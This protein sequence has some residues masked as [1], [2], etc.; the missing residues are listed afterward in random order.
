MASPV[1]SDSAR[2]YGLDW[3][4]VFAFL[5][6]IFYHSGM[7]FVT[8]PWHVKNPE[9]STALEYAMLFF[10]H[11]RLGLLFFI[12]GAGVWFSL[13]RRGWLE[14][15]GERL[16]RLA[17]PVLFGI[18]VIVPPQIYFERLQQGRQFE[19]YAAFYATVFAF[20][21]YPE[22][23]TSWHHLWFVVY[24][25]VYS[26]AAIPFFL[27]WRRSAGTA[28]RQL[29][30]FLLRRQPV[31]YLA[32]LP[33][34][35]IALTLGP[36]W[37]VTHNLVSD[38]ANL[39]GSFVTFLWG[40]AIC[41]RPALLDAITARRREFLAGGLLV[42]AIFYFLRWS[43][44]TALW[45][46]DLRFAARVVID[47]YFGM[48]WIF[49]LLGYARQYANRPSPWLS[50]AT[51]AVYPFYI[52][53]QTI[54]VAL[55]YAIAPV[56]LSLWIKLAILMAGTFA[57]SWLVFEIVRRLDGTRLLFGLKPLPPSGN[58]SVRKGNLADSKE[59]A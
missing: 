10:N 55:G 25:L 59:I 3:L 17:I 37:P 53:H 45:P 56:A 40:F 9:T 16:R 14:F 51:E 44:A 34:I 22:G 5:I 57:G 54:T 32:T 18:F 15:A 11:W 47:A 31:L 23:S 36:R 8:W 24:I 13:R 49:T 19:S 1:Q 20:V 29:E 58:G 6:L 7:F 41:S 2:E 50:Y 27:W 48:F 12:S 4:R 46:G 26:L 21:S 35:A 30:R 52:V 38:W 42:A 39:T 28:G 33:S 43:G